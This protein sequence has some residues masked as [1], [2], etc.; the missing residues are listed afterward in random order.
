MNNLQVIQKFLNG[1]KGATAKRNIKQ[2]YYYIEG[3][4]LQTDGDKLTNYTTDIAKKNGENE[5]E[6]DT[7]YYSSTTTKIQT[8]LIKE[9]KKYRQIG[10]DFIVVLNGE[11]KRVEKFG[12]LLQ[13]N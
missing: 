11:Q 4:T 9:I 13:E 10:Y 6:I 8:M 12:E 7:S 2:D 3:R 5:I 1:E